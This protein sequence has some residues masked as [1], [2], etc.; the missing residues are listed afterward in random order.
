MLAIES[1]GG[2][3]EIDKLETAVDME[4]LRNLMPVPLPAGARPLRLIWELL[5]GE[6]GSEIEVVFSGT[7]DRPVDE[8]DMYISS[9][10]L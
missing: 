1:F 7:C 3:V 5:V 4:S 6:V 2:G 9:W 10:T 8:E